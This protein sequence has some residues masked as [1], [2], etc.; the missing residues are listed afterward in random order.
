MASDSESLNED[1]ASDHPLI[2]KSFSV[3]C[4]TVIRC[5]GVVLVGKSWSSG[6][7]SYPWWADPSITPWVPGGKD[8]TYALSLV[9]HLSIY[10][11]N[12][13]S[14]Y[15]VVY[16]GPLEQVPVNE[17]KNS[18]FLIHPL[19]ITRSLLPMSTYWRKK[20]ACEVLMR[21]GA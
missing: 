13:S 19:S 12:S 16:L 15:I 5:C 18:V 6:G 1:L 3:R 10:R 14:L 7:L 21:G 9:I 8:P 20:K 4:L 17:L 11:W 2:K